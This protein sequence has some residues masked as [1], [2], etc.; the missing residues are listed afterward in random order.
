M[1]LEVLEAIAVGKPIAETMATLC[2]RVEQIAPD[3]ICT[4]IGVEADGHIH[5]IAAPSMPPEFSAAMDGL[6]VGPRAGSCG[7]AAFRGEPVVVA[8]IANDP[9]WADYRHCA[10]PF[11]LAA[12][13]SSPIKDSRGNVAATFAMYYREP[14]APDE[15]HREIV[16]ASTH[17]VSVALQHAEA[18]DRLGESERH[19]REAELVAGMGSFEWSVGSD[20]IVWSDQLARIYGYEPEGYP[21]TLEGFMTR[22]HPDDRD[23]IRKNIQN[24]L[25]SGTSWTM[26]ERIIR[27][28]TAE[29][30][31]LSSRVKAMRNARNEIVRLCGICHDVTE[32]RRAEEALVT[33]ETRFRRVFDDAPTGMVLIERQGDDFV[34]THANEAMAYLLGYAVSELSRMPL[35]HIVDS[36]DGP[37]LQ[38]LLSRAVFE[39]GTPAHLEIR[40]RAK[41][42]ES[43][44][45]L[46]AASRIGE[47]APGSALILHLEDLTLSKRVEQQLRHRALYD[48]LTGLPNR[49]LLLDRL[50]GALAR[51]GLS[52]ASV[53]VLFLNLDNFKIVNDTIG[54]AAGNEML[55]AMANRMVS[56]AGGADTTARVGGDE[57]VIL[58]ENVE[59][60]EELTSLA[61]QVASE[62]ATPISIGG[63]E[64]ITTASIG[65]ALG[66]QGELP[67]QL[68]RDADLAMFHAKKRGKSAVEIFDEG[69]RR[70]AIGRVEVERDLRRALKAGE[71]VPYYQPIVELRTG[72]IGG[73]EALARW[74]HPDR[75]VLL[76]GEF[77]SIAEEAHLIGALGEAMLAQACRQLAIWEKQS[78]KL[79][80]A[81]NVSLLQLDSGFT[82]VVDNV[83]RAYSVAPRAV[84]AEI[85]ESVFLDMHESAATNLN[86]L[87][88]L[89]VRLGIDDFGTGYSSLL[90][91]KRFPVQFLKIDRS[92]VNGLP[93]NKEDAAI[94]K[95]IVL[96][97]R[98]LELETIAEGVETVDQLE[99]L[100]SLGCTYAQG[101]FIAEP[102]PAHECALE[103]PVRHA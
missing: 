49:D 78:P 64:F 19:L 74:I 40:L 90:Y 21:R 47:E 55:R 10:V 87:A 60:E 89:G 52:R 6:A 57:F 31:V 28:D 7:T 32:Q 97:G 37:L 73:F 98:S 84:L 35:S 101:Y 12:C 11:G 27:A 72:A 8:D 66:G 80:M 63:R 22:V 91:L 85:T 100:R 2:R 5:P 45:V 14:R 15:F 68:L 34:I 76:P 93:G 75:G 61:R 38:A 39:R 82:T 53:G 70:R 94:V 23:N 59:S 44:S 81:V 62:L 13:W 43:I 88:G 16:D 33:S 48:P 42:D 83:I 3:L 86:A 54:Y 17:L 95:A 24:A 65:V 92:F 69:L 67:E 102:K 99:L 103:T 41:D 26:D 77:L 71:I 25:A 79:T 30:R 18:L 1:Q 58:C 51:S 36:S 9:L 20:E 4:V 46:C 96:L 56:V 50:N 29:M